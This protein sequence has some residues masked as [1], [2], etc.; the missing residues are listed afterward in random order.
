MRPFTYDGAPIVGGPATSPTPIIAGDWTDTLA[1]HGAKKNYSYRLQDTK[2][3][4]RLVAYLQD[5]PRSSA[6]AYVHV[7]GPGGRPCDYQAP[8]SERTFDVRDVLSAQVRIGAGS[9]QC[10]RP[11]TYRFEV[12]RDSEATATVPVGLRVLEEPAVVDPGWTTSHLEAAAH[13]VATA[14]GNHPALESGQSFLNAPLVT[15][16]SYR[17]TIVSGESDLV[18]VHL[19]YGQSLRVG[20]TFPANTPGMQQAL[21]Q[22]TIWDSHAGIALY[23]PTWTH[24]PPATGSKNTEFAGV[25][26]AGQPAATRLYDATAPVTSTADGSFTG[27]GGS[28]SRAGDYYVGVS[29]A[30]ADNAVE[31]PFI[32]TIAV[33]G[34]AR[35][36]PTF[37]DDGSSASAPP[38]A[39][40][41]RGV[42]GPH[43]ANR[44]DGS[45]TPASVLVLLGAMILALLGGGGWWWRRRGGSP[46]GP[47]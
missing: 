10:H 17:S 28:T 22:G 21:D 16:G 1:G 46:T 33:H 38:S 18:R 47:P 30:A 20:V 8:V 45:G 14:H 39:S 23:D 4:V 42:P 2:T 29:M 15:P 32:L 3:T 25:D 6:A 13:P 5:Q 37:T 11:G 27:T 44:P 12:Y 9:K 35:K 7:Y 24:L 19:D 26:T 43:S 36:A 34:N 41:G 40:P 31:H